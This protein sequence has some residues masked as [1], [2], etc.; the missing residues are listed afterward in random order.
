MFLNIFSIVMQCMGLGCILFAVECFKPPIKRT[1]KNKIT[2]N[3]T[4]DILAGIFNL[5]LGVILFG[6]FGIF[7]IFGDFPTGERL[8]I[9]TLPISILITFYLYFQFPKTKFWKNRAKA[10]KALQDG[11]DLLFRL[12]GQ[13]IMLV[14]AGHIIFAIYVWLRSGVWTTISLGDWGYNDFKLSDYG[15]FETDWWAINKVLNYVILDS[16]AAISIIP[17]GYLIYA[18]VSDD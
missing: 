4:G 16:S 18:S 11:S 6:M 2:G 1:K 14:G 13:A 12:I 8:P 5:F 3:T 10:K 7:L 9:W 17:L 15:R